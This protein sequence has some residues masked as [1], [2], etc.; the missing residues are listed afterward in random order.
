MELHFPCKLFYKIIYSANHSTVQN[1]KVIFVRDFYELPGNKRN[2]GTQNRTNVNFL[3]NTPCINIKYLING[4]E[5]I[6]T[7]ARKALL[8]KSGVI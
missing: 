8:F 3:A 6:F 7:I 1:R 2:N 5:C 4:R